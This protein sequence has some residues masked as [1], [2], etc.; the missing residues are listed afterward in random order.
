MLV[1]ILI[2]TAVVLVAL[3][4]YVAT[5][6]GEFSVSRSATFA[7]PA[8]AVFAQVNELKKWEAWSPWEKIDPAIKRSYSGA[9]SGKGAVYAWQGNKDI[10]QG[11]MEILESTP[12]SKVVIKIDFIQPIEAHNTIEFRLERQGDGAKVTQAMYGPSSF[13]S[14]LVGLFCSMD[15]MIG[16]KF[17]EGLT[18]LKSIVEK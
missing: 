13:L 1:K 2:G 9:D 11:R 8:P 3:V 16:Q 14:K 17:D 10:G 7:A 4:A 18:S 5:Q 12:S 6:P 15:K